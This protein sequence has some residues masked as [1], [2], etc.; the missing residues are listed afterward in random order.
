MFVRDEQGIAGLITLKDMIREETIAAIEKLKSV[1]V[2]HIYA[3]R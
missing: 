3:D 1:G 2:S